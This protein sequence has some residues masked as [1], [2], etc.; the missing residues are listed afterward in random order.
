MRAAVFEYLATSSMATRQPEDARPRA[1]ER[2]R[3]GTGP[4]SPASPEGARRGRRGTHRCGRS[5]GPAGLT[6]SW[7]SRRT[8]RCSSTSL[9]GELE[10]HRAPRSSAPSEAPPDRFPSGTGGILP[11]PGDPR[12]ARP[13]VGRPRPPTPTRPAAEPRRVD[14]RLCSAR[15]HARA[16]GTPARWAA[17][18]AGRGDRWS[19]RPWS[20]SG[21]APTSTPATASTRSRRWT[22]S[23]WSPRPRP[24]SPSTSCWWGRTPGRSSTQQSRPPSSAHPA[25]QGGQR[26]DVTIVA[27][28][29]PATKQVWV[30]SIPR[31]LWVD[32]PG[33]EPGVSGT[34]RINA[35][36]NNG[37]DLLI[38]TIETGPGDPHQPLHVGRHSRASRTW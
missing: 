31:D 6:L 12:A 9:L 20:C 16:A 10:V 21:P 28:F 27:R 25:V 34:N 4:S 30:L 38:Q 18:A 24:A 37:P 2:P 7:A 19:W 32:I 35:A 13:A 14:R 26:S 23:T 22:P 36:F 11:A 1:A 17:G 3:A 15:P 29:I 33:D 8:D 5:P